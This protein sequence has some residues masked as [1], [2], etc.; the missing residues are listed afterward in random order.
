[1]CPDVST[2]LPWFAVRVRSNCERTAAMHLRERG[3]EEF[4]PCFKAQRQWSD[5]KKIIDQFLFPGYVFARLNPENR[6]PVLSA[7]GVVGMVGFGKVPCPIPDREID[8]IR[9]LVQSGLLVQPWPFLQIGERVLIERGPLAGV[10]GLLEQV[11][12]RYRLVVSVELLQRA[13]S[14]EV[15][16]DWV[17]PL[18]PAYAG[19]FHMQHAPAV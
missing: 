7:P 2:V 8:G 9:A 5:R 17:R 4:A 1:M 12:G 19:G 14:A 13:V 11:K 6:L 10:E 16:R 15:D 18:K 3:Y